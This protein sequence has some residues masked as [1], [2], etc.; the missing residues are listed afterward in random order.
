MSQDNIFKPSKDFK[1]QTFRVI[2]NTKS[3]AFYTTFYN[4]ETSNDITNIGKTVVEMVKDIDV[5]TP[6]LLATTLVSEG[7]T[8]QVRK[9][10]EEFGIDNPKI[11]Y[12]HKRLNNNKMFIVAYPHNPTQN[13][14]S[15]FD[16]KVHKLNTLIGTPNV[17]I[18]TKLIN[19]LNLNNF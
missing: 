3:T 12:L 7:I 1:G 2:P 8:K 10:F 5:N 11:Y 17:D 9:A 15:M 6:N 14:I 4:E 18:A 16:E 19:K 13:D